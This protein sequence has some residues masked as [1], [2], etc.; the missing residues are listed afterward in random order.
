MKLYTFTIPGNAAEGSLRAYTRRMLPELAEYMVREAFEKRDVKVNGQRVGK[1]ARVVPGAQVWLYAREAVPAPVIPI[2]YAD[3]NLLVVGKPI[4]I[5]CEPDAKGGA[6][7]G[8]LALKALQQ[9]DAHAVMPLLCHR[10]DNQT[11]G[12]LLLARNER[13]QAELMEAFRHRQVHKTYTCLVRGTPRPEHLVM[14][15]FLLKDAARAMVRILP[16]EERGAQRII[17]EYTVLEAGDCARL[18]IALH[19]GRT[20]QIRAHMAS[21]G[22]PLLGDDQYGDRAFNRRYQAKRLMLC[23][24]EL[25]FAL[26]GSLRYLNQKTFTYQPSF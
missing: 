15:A 3:E 21:I 22:H 11:D 19:T 6:T 26:E 13:V 8:E 23:A 12:L 20:H 18:S 16:H 24:T 5:S 4:G 1:D 17:T 14:N 25:R 9:Q 10:L 7:I 2:V